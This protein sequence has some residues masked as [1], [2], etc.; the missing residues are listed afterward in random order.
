MFYNFIR[1]SECSNW[2]KLFAEES[3]MFNAGPA[4]LLHCLIDPLT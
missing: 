1:K 4:A 3:L 2:N